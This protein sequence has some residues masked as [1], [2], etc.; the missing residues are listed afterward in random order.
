MRIFVILHVIN[1]IQTCSLPFFI[2]SVKKL[3][4]VLSGCLDYVNVITSKHC[5]VRGGDATTVEQSTRLF[6]S[7]KTVNK[8]TTWK[9]TI[10]D[11]SN[12]YNK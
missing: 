11:N 5:G 8:N 7:I 1:K 3:I 10:R 6:L 12:N 2:I 4:S 9:Q